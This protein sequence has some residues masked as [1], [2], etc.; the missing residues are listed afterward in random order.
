MHLRNKQRRNNQKINPSYIFFQSIIFQQWGCPSQSY[1]NGLLTRGQQ[2][3]FKW[4]SSCWKVY[5]SLPKCSYI[6]GF[7]GGSVV[8]NPP[9]KARDNTRDAGLI[10]GW[11]RAPGEGNG[12]PFQYSCMENSL[13]RGAWWATVHG[14]KKSQTRVSMHACTHVHIE[15]F[16]YSLQM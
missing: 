1:S 9:A 16:T 8:K 10:S 12:N 14:V 15:G 4:N 6:R 3:S 2:Q 13:D 11:G 5:F 7:P